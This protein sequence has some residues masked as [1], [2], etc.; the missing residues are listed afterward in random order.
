M[1][2][3]AQLTRHAVHAP[4]DSLHPTPLLQ[5]AHNPSGPDG[6]GRTNLDAALT[7][8]AQAIRLHRADHRR[9]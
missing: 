1:G 8:R 2:L 7:R 3:I 6:R 9:R 4:A 5:S